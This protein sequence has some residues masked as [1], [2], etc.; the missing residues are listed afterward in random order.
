[1]SDGA[2]SGPLYG[3]NKCVSIVSFRNVGVGGTY[4]LLKKQTRFEETLCGTS[5]CESL[6]QHRCA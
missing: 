5:H 6:H 1:M 2:Q 3:G 4:R